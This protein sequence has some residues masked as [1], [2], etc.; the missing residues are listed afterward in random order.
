MTVQFVYED[1]SAISQAGFETQTHKVAYGATYAYDAPALDGFTATPAQYTGVMPAQNL[2]LLFT[3]YEDAALMEMNVTVTWGNLSFTATYGKWDPEQLG[4]EPDSFTPNAIGQNVV[5]VAN[6]SETVNV[7]A[8]LAYGATDGFESIDGYFTSEEDAKAR[9]NNTM[10]VA[11][12]ESGSLYVWIDGELPD[13]LPEN[14]STVCGTV[15]VTITPQ[16]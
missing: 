12:K 15:T 9:K 8:V 6:D 2:V 5:T 14:Q 7:N 11:V 13:S 1:G 10:A 4:Y 3:Y 16:P